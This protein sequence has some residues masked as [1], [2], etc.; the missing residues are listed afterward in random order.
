MN[1]SE[2]NKMKNYSNAKNSTTIEPIN[3]G[4]KFAK[5]TDLFGNIEPDTRV[6]FKPNEVKVLGYLKTH[7]EMYDK[8]Q[9]ALYINY[10]GVYYLMN[11]STW[12]GRK[13]EVDFINEGANAE[14]FF[15]DCSISSISAFMTK[16]NT[17]SYNVSVFEN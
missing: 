5:I 6:E 14:E 8:D 13:L 10:D 11:V 9:Y 17:L 16:F 7:S 12:Y 1:E 3:K 4:A 2:E 15:K